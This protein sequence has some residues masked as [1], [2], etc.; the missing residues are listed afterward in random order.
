MKKYLM[1]AAILGLFGLSSAPAKADMVTI[2]WVTPRPVMV[3]PVHYFYPPVY[4]P[5]YRPV[6]WAHLPR[7]HRVWRHCG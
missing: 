1:L 3:Q 5:V 4:R 6:R 7:H 2:A